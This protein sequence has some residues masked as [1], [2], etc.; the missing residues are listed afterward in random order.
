MVGLEVLA[1]NRFIVYGFV[2]GGFLGALGISHFISAEPS[3]VY[4]VITKKVIEVQVKERFVDRVVD[5]V[6]YRNRRVDRVITHPDGTTIAES[7]RS[8]DTEQEISKTQ[9]LE[10]TS[11]VSQAESIIKSEEKRRNNRWLLGLSS[12]STNFSLQTTELTVGRFIFEPVALT[13][14]ANLALNT[15]RVGLVG[16]F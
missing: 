7:E 2:V 14:S 5:R 9:E 13:F 10:K 1:R 16:I 12:S 11:S 8:S 6:V 3:Y 15:F 4:K